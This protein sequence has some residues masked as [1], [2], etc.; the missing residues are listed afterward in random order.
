VTWRRPGLTPREIEEIEEV[1]RVC[2]LPPLI[3]T[4]GLGAHKSR[5]DKRDEKV[6]YGN[7]LLARAAIECS[8]GNGHQKKGG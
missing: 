2:A 1:V 4:C 7:A 6:Q 5:F 8:R 3:P